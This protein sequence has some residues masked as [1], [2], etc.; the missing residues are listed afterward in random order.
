MAGCGIV[1]TIL[2]CVLIY[3]ISRLFLDEIESAF[4]VLAFLFV[5]AFGFYTYTGIFNFILPYSF[6]STFF[7]L[8]VSLAL[9]SFL[10]FILHER[11][12]HLYLWSGAM[13][14]SFFCRID[15]S[16]VVLAGFIFSGLIL[17][18]KNR[19]FAG[20]FPCLVLPIIISLL[21]YYLF[22]RFTGSFEEF[23]TG[24]FDYLGPVLSGKSSVFTLRMAGLDNVRYNI[25]LA[26]KPVMIY[27]VIMA[28]LAVFSRLKKYLKAENRPDSVFIILGS[29]LI[30]V[31]FTNIGGYFDSSFQYRCLPLVLL[32]CTILFFIRIFLSDNF[33]KSALLFTLF[34]TALLLSLRVFLNA[35]PHNY[36]FYL[37]SI[38]VI[39]YYVFF[40]E[41]FYDFMVR[42]FKADGR[43]FKPLVAVFLV[44]LIMPDWG[45]SSKLYA[46][47]DLVVTT[48]RGPVICWRNGESALFWQAVDYLSKNT[49]KADT[50]VVFPEGASINFFA[51][52]D[53]PIKYYSFL[54]HDFKTIGESKIISDLAAARADYIVILS[55]D[56]SEYGFRAFGIDYAERTFAW[57]RENYGVIKQFGPIPYTTNEFGVTILKRN[58]L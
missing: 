26:L 7:I 52:R 55:R 34:L 5:F 53:T 39:C 24:V 56:T 45:I 8:F 3:K 46:A 15:I 44:F 27:T 17:I 18:A 23:K 22:L 11:I 14:C 58:G 2:V 35:T 57:I 31:I 6:S 32:A 42:F 1:V 43:I 51:D 38:G 33:K 13:A 10:M 40:F 25:F 36:G 9:Y 48:N 49:G 16:A 29:M 37:L 4:P 19:R 50:I 47:K 20:M 54:P 21:G 30:L 12:S 28:L 41:I